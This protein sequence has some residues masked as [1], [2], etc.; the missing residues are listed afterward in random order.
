MAVSTYEEVRKRIEEREA[1]AATPVE[2][3]LLGRVNKARADM[4]KG[5]YAAPPGPVVDPLA[6]FSEVLYLGLAND[7]E[8]FTKAAADKK[9]YGD[10][11]YADKG[12]QED[13]KERYPLDTETHI[14]AAWGYINQADNKALYS[15]ADYK[16]VHD[17]IAAAMKKIGAEVEGED[18]KKSLADIM[19]AWTAAIAA[20]FATLSDEEKASLQAIWN[21][22]F[23]EEFASLAGTE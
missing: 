4:G 10:V 21:A 20:D 22:A 9:P 8:A 11:Q 2:S 7:M 15:A 14:R 3:V 13:G 5:P 16:K 12:Y 6:G 17:A 23:G 18:T 19:A 1:R